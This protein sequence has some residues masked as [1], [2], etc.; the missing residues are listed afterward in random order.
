MK[1]LSIK[2]KNKQFQ[3]LQRIAKA[4]NRKVEDFLYLI[5]STGL[6][7][8]F[9][10]TPISVEKLPEEYSQKELKQLQ[11]NKKLE[12]M[13]HQGKSF[14]SLD[15]DE[16][17]ALGHNYVAKWFSNSLAPSPDSPDFIQQLA[18]SIKENSLTTFS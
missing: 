1:K 16:R 9:C 17:E 4:D 5:L 14:H 6:E 2:L 10:E 8:Q 7:Y 15:L 12:N 13:E 3:M 11:L 18:D